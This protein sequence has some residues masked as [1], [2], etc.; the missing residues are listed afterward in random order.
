MTKN[1]RFIDSGDC[2]AYLNMAIDE[3]IAISVR[4]KKSPPT[5]RIYGWKDLSVSLGAFQ[6]ISNVNVQYCNLNNIPIVRRPT[7]GR[8]ILHGNELTYSFSC[9]NEG[10]FATGLLNSYKVLSDVFINAFQKIGLKVE[11]RKTRASGRYLTRDSLCFNSISYGEIT[12]DGM[13]IIGS[14]QK[15]WDKGFLQQGSIPFLI[16]YEILRTV[17]VVDT[18]DFNFIGIKELLPNLNKEELKRKIKESF[19][20]IFFISFIDSPLYPF[21][22]ELVQSLLLEKYQNNLWTENR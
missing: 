14:A 4:E 12:F 10:P 11:S 13:K 8:G 20:K 6:K 18:K 5:L 7:G 15:R 22:E 19:E 2:D 3:A 17:F 21:E 9:T 1:W 16:D